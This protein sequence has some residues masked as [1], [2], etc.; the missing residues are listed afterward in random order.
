V[1]TRQPPLHGETELDKKWRSVHA[2]YYFC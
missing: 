2:V 1:I